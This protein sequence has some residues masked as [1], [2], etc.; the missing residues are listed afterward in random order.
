[1]IRSFLIICVSILV[2]FTSGFCFLGKPQNNST[3]IKKPSELILG[4]YASPPKFKGGKVDTKL[5]ISQ[6]IDLNANTY[7][8]LLLDDSA[9]IVDL[10]TFLPLA[11]KNNIN[12][13]VTILPVTEVGLAKG[14]YSID[15]AFWAK[16]IAV[17][18][19]SNSN[20][21]TWSVDD[22]VHN[23]KTYTPN[24]LLKV[25][26]VTK[27]INPNLKFVPCCYFPSIN[28]KF[29]N[30][31]KE[32]MDGIIFPY[33]NESNEINLQNSNNVK[34]EI[35]KIKEYLGA[36][37]PVIVDVYS[38]RHSKLGATSTNYVAEV[39]DAAIKNSEGVIIYTHPNPLI[40]K[41]NFDEKYA[42]IKTAF[43]AIKK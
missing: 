41:E 38:S 34:S 22:F 23:L 32:I 19:K 27:A 31:Y 21:T 25:Q 26:K 30:N 15:L 11:K 20:L 33:R 29:A 13:W 3:T 12:V 24:Y 39:I 37:F 4:T 17:L 8:W 36:N 18:S 10:K 5:L 16:K 6:L 28:Q 42:A 9:S 43:S 1:M 14:K 7:N 2:L 40:K 35:L